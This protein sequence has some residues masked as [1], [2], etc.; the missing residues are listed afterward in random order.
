MKKEDYIILPLSALS[1]IGIIV[2]LF[3]TRSGIGISPDSATYIGVS[4]NVLTGKG[5]ILPFGSEATPM[6]H[7]PPLFPVVL[8][9]LGFSGGDPLNIARW[10]N[11]LLFGANI[12]LVGLAINKYTHSLCLSISGSFL[13]LTSVDMLGI[14]SMA[15]TE[16]LFI[17]LGVLGLLLLDTYTEDQKPL[18]IIISS[19]AIA[20]GFLTRYIGIVLVTTG[21]GGI[22]FLCKK[23]YY[24]KFIDIVI[25]TSISSLPI[26]V[27]VIRN[28]YVSG[29][30]AN[31]KFFFHPITVYHFRYAI[32]TI[33]RLFLPETVHKIVRAIVLFVVIIALLISD[34]FLL[35]KKRKDSIR[36]RGE[37]IPYLLILFILIYTGFLIFS[38][39]FFDAHTLMDYRIL[40]PIYVSGLILVLWMIQRLLSYTKEIPLLKSILLLTGIAFSGSYLVRG[41]WW[42]IH[43]SRDG[44]GYA[45]KAWHHSEII[46]KIRNLPSEIPI[47]TN[48]PDAVYILTGRST[49]MIPDKVNPESRQTNN[50]YLS[51]IDRMREW[52]K[53]KDGVLIYFNTIQRWYLPQE[54]ELKEQ[55][56]LLLIEKKTDGSIYKISH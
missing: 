17:F 37:K 10:F 46:K 42:I 11:A 26:I 1:I 55:L 30:M 14:H 34:I 15:W 24:R 39:S 21:I 35:I 23:T 52:L 33:S 48:L 22:F 27:W 31:R 43:T 51:E 13:M 36:Q 6:T 19:L 38:I 28:L 50:N 16:P 3:S 9:I 20:L 49:F 53:N 32:D 44:Q 45:S 18:F 2:L 54:N 7:Y 56:Q 41:T 29:T 4:R 8:A 40:S 5:L 12:T 47:F 25:L